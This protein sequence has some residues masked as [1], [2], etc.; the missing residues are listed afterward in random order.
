MMPSEVICFMSTNPL[1]L[2]TSH[3]IEIF[4]WCPCYGH[5]RRKFF[6]VEAGDPYFR[7][8]ML[9][10]FCQ[11]FDLEQHAWQ[12]APEERLLIRQEQE[13]PIIDE[14][15][16][17][18]KNRLIDGKLLPKSKFKEALG[19]FAS[20]TPYLKNYTLYPN[21]RLDNN[22]A[23]RAL[24][25]LAIGRKNWLF[26]GSANGGQAAAVLL[27]LVQ[28]CRGLNINPRVYLEDLFRRFMDHPANRL[29]ELLPDVWKQKF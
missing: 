9:R 26:F 2:A 17:K 3:I 23:E 16:E 8:W 21:A 15:I 1:L 12:Q 20:L 7:D 28:T 18:V 19:Y 14:M 11:V 25:P 29:E 13:V 24:R 4:D 10:S 6:E 22:V 5:M 27:S